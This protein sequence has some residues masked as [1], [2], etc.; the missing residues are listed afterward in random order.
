MP[1]R[2]TH[3]AVCNE[4]KPIIAHLRDVEGCEFEP[5]RGQ[6]LKVYQGGH[7]KDTMPMRIVGRG[8]K[9]VEASLRRKG[10]LAGYG[11]PAP[12]PKKKP[13]PARPVQASTPQPPAAPAAPPQEVPVAAAPPAPEP[14]P[15]PAPAP[16]PAVAVVPT[17]QPARPVRAHTA[18]QARLDNV[19]G[20]IFRCLTDLG[21]NTPEVRQVFVKHVLDEGQ[22]AGLPLPQPGKLGGTS[23][24]AYESLRNSLGAY[25]RGGGQSQRNLDL[26]ENGVMALARPR[27]QVV[28]EHQAVAQEQ[29]ATG[30]TGTAGISSSGGPGSG[31][32]YT[33]ERPPGYEPTPELPV[34]DH[35][36]WDVQP[37][38]GMAWAC[39]E[40]GC[41]SWASLAQNAGWHQHIT[42]H[43]DPVLVAITDLPHQGRNDEER[44]PADRVVPLHPQLAP[45]PPPPDLVPYM[46]VPSDP[47]AAAKASATQAYFDQL[48]A[49]SAEGDNDARDRLERLLGL[50]HDG[51]QG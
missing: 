28:P 33:S 12:K 50:D 18:H 30:S 19:R 49:K 17:P 36:S 21:G 3:P 45:P 27:P 32:L 24:S 15:V 25:L 40:E 13:A 7:L 43:G 16:A 38:E 29:A 6:K 31:L 41:L 9:N 23:S 14:E 46:P 1:K 8:R 4:L 5:T 48:V 20:M 22:R 34:W 42:K 39:Q 2:T 51:R 44:D 37:P 35:H 26:W 11:E 47:V 10:L